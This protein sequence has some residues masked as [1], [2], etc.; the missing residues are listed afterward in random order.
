MPQLDSEPAVEQIGEAPDENP[1]ENPEKWKWVELHSIGAFFSGKTP[2]KELLSNATGIPYF[3]V[4]D[5]N[6]PGNEIYLTKTQL[7]VNPKAKIK[8]YPP[9]S[10]V[11]S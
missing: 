10:I 7:F 8:Q 1:F 2:N 11:F 3:K 4:S 9:A 6:T 5:M